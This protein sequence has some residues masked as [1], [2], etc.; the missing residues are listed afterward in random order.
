MTVADVTDDLVE[1]AM[2][3]SRGLVALA[4]RSLEAIEPDVTLSQF[5]MLVV[6]ATAGPQTLRSLADDIGASPSSA[7]RICDRLEQKGLLTRTMATRSRRELDVAITD[8]G[9]SIVDRVSAERRAE[10][11]R[12][13]GEVPDRRRAAML[14]SIAEL[15]DLLGASRPDRQRH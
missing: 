10:L 3:A 13:L 14:R 7:S 1:A 15:A 4:A 5:R 2:A 6:L 11:T 12:I 8:E 9:S